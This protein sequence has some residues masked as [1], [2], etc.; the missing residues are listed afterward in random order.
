[1]QEQELIDYVTSEMDIDVELLRKV[2]ITIDAAGMLQDLLP[3][4]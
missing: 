3:D 2:I 1:M 4:D